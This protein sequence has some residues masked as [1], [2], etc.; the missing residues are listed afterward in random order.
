MAPRLQPASPRHGLPSRTGRALAHPSARRVPS[1]AHCFEVRTADE[2]LVLVFRYGG[3]LS[4]EAFEAT[5]RRTG[6]LASGRE[7]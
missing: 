7:T 5:G 2:S 4:L 3:A 1:Q 6:A